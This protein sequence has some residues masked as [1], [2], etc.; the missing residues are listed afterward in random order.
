KGEG[1]QITTDLTD[2]GTFT[3]AIPFSG[4]ATV[5][6]ATDHLMTGTE[7]KDK[8]VKQQGDLS[9][10]EK[11]QPLMKEKMEKMIPEKKER[12]QKLYSKT[13]AGAVGTYKTIDAKHAD[14]KKSP[15]SVTIESG[16]QV[17]DFDG[18]H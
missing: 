17:K 11:Q 16:A 2:K 6:V 18:S 5:T 4:E 3:V 8:S 1:G 15:L 13:N 14:P 12:Y 7:G 9:Q 10:F